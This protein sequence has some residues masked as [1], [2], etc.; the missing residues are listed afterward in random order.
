MLFLNDYYLHLYRVWR[1]P[2]SIPLLSLII[3]RFDG[4]ERVEPFTSSTV[5]KQDGLQPNS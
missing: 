1:L 2:I 5:P 3:F 4:G